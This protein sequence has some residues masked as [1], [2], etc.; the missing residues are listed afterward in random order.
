MLAC[1]AMVKIL[2]RDQAIQ[3]GKAR[4]TMHVI[5]TVREMIDARARWSTGNTVGLVPTM[6]YLHEGHL[7]LVRSARAEN[8]FLAISIFVNPTQFGPHEDLERYPRDLPR[9]LRLLE[10]CGVDV[11][12]VPAAAEMYPSGFATYVDP[13]GPLV[14]AAEG[15]SR[16]G[17][18]RGVATIVLKLFQVLTP[19]RAY[20]GQKDAQQVAVI[21]RMVADFNLPVELRVLSTI[22]E[23][24][25]L[26]MSSRNAYLARE[27]RAASIRLYQ[28]LQA[29]KQTFEAGASEGPAAVVR[30][31]QEVVDAEPRAVLDYAEVRDP[32]TF[33]PL[34]RLQAPALLLIA[35][36]VGS[37][38]LIDN[39]LLRADG[40]WETGTRGTLVDRTKG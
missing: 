20:F 10:E 11:V 29:G 15:A 13:L 17:H 19:T 6:G 38:R 14:T 34:D 2:L 39:F 33:S 31:M 18:F 37:T 7:S 5:T 9:D 35:A 8:T 36:T 27:A 1:F 3:D 28:A 21:A 26:A 40:T 22:R 12:F 30:A 4:E 16:P 24:D 23:A 32:T 25:G